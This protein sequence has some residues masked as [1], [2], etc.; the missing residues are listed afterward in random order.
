M[1]EYLH[2]LRIQAACKA[3]EHPEWPLSDIALASGFADHSHFCRVFKSRIG[4]SPGRF[5]ALLGSH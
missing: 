5:R 2:N 4:C 3:L 1:G